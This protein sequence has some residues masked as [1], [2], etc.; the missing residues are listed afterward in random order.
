MR[1]ADLLTPGVA[2]RG[3]A[4]RRSCSRGVGARRWGKFSAPWPL[5]ATSQRYAGAIHGFAVEFGCRREQLRPGGSQP[6][7]GPVAQVA[8]VFFPVAT[9]VAIAV[10]TVGRSLSP[11]PAPVSTTTAPIATMGA[12]LSRT[13]GR[14]WLGYRR[15]RLG[16]PAPVPRRP[17]SSPH[18]TTPDPA[19]SL[20]C[21]APRSVSTIHRTVSET[22]FPAGFISGSRLLASGRRRWWRTR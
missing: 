3:P 21:V 18:D 20:H 7:S 16:P 10:A 17:P 8:A 2:S 14:V 9:Q 11:V 4:T 6:A 15:E 12:G 13:R 5:I 1:L 22:G 19:T